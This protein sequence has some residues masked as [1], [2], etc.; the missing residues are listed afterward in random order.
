MS[1]ARCVIR[2]H[3]AFL[4]T[5]TGHLD[6]G[7]LIS[8]YDISEL[9]RFAVPYLVEL[10]SHYPTTT[11]TLLPPCPTPAIIFSFPDGLYHERYPPSSAHPMSS[12]LLVRFSNSFKIAVGPAQL[13]WRMP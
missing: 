10:Y 3:V 11:I 12:L 8:L 7:C 2:Y 9:M 5:Y 6:Y 4:C 13:V 1:C